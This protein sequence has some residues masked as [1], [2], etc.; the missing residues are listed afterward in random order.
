LAGFNYIDEAC[1]VYIDELFKWIRR[2][3]RLRDIFTLATS[4]ST[5]VLTAAD[6]GKEALLYVTQ[7]LGFTSGVISITADSY[8]YRVGPTRFSRSSRRFRPSI[9][10][11]LRSATKA[12]FNPC[13]HR[14]RS[15]S[16]EATWR[17]VSR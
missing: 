3:N 13:L 2:K 7:A 9:A 1:D 11:N 8:L 15:T 16:S 4:T 12:A 6:A 14:S 17:C 10:R 5:A